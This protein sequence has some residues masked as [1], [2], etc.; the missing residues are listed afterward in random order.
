M[1]TASEINFA[2]DR[3]TLR[4]YP[5]S[6]S[7]PF[8]VRL[9]LEGIVTV[10]PAAHYPECQGAAQVGRPHERPP[11]LELANMNHFVVARRLEFPGFTKSVR[12]ATPSRKGGCDD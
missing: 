9:P 3:I 8:S 12:I 6:F 7:T 1:K 11:S 10:G 2:R 4:S 5:G